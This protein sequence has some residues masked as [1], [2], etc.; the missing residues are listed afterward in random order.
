VTSVL[1]G[2]ASRWLFFAAL[3][4]APWAYGGTTS[5][6][7]QMI[8][9]LLLGALTLWIVDLL[10]NRRMPKFPRLL[11]V[12]ILALMAI[13]GWMAFNASGICDSE[14][15]TFSRLAKPAPRLPGS[16]DY[17][18]SVAWMIRAGLLLGVVLFIV[19]LAQD[20]RWL[21]WL[22]Y[23]IGLVA[24]SVALLGLLQKAT[25]ARMIFWQPAPYGSR[26][27]FASYYYHANAGAYLNLVLPITAGLAVR[28]FARHGNPGMRAVWLSVFLLTLIAVF[29]NTSRM[30]QVIGIVLLIALAWQLGPQIVRRLSRMEKN[31]ALAGAAAVVVALFGVAQAIH[32]EQPIQRWQ[33]L[34]ISRDA[35]WLA[36]SVAIKSIPEAGFFGFGPGTFRVAFPWLNDA[37]GTPAPGFWRFLHQDYLQVALEWGCLGSL[38]WALLFFGGI[39]VAF[40][41]FRSAQNWTPRRRLLLPLVMIALGGVA[42][43]ALVDFPLQIAS[44]QLYVATYV[45]L[46]WGSARWRAARSADELS[47]IR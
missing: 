3:A 45:G 4:Y 15:Y 38:L 35:R 32:L 20:N 39:F 36:G 33:T 31:V 22:W 7:I 34:N 46:C 29:A 21:L 8:N 28:A 30:A 10:I 11:L 26:Y 40:R 24:G 47:V 17:A 41:N 19:D 5:G 44:I 6:S 37:A 18:L 42:L 9:W 1:F 43:H 25:G 16:I 14:F 2:Y 23:A 27:F 13:G 12:L